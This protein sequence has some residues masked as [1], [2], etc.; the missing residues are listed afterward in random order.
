VEGPNNNS[1]HQ[2]FKRVKKGGR[3]SASQ[4]NKLLDTV[5]RL[6]GQS[7]Q[8]SKSYSRIRLV[9]MNEVMGHFDHEDYT[10][11]EDREGQ[12]QWYDTSAHTID[13]TGRDTQIKA[14]VTDPWGLVYDDNERLAVYYNEQSGKCIPLN[15]RTVRHAVTW[16]EI[17]GGSG[18]SQDCNV[19]F[20]DY[21]QAD[22]YP[23]VYPIKFIKIEYIEQA[24]QQ[25]ATTSYLN[26]TSCPDAYV[27]NVAAT[28]GGVADV[29]LPI[30]CPLQVYS[31]VGR[32]GQPQWFT[33]TCCE[34]DESSS[35]QSGSGSSSSQSQS[36]DS[37]SSGGSS[38]SSSESSQSASSSSSGGSSLSSNSSSGGS[39][40]SSGGSSGSSSGGS[41]MS[42]GGS[43]LSE[44]DLS[45]SGS[46]GFTCADFVT[47]LSFNSDTCVLTYCVKTVCFPDGLG[48][49]VSEESC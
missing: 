5:E 15:P 20:L 42:S 46:S 34:F 10:A 44:S 4:Q 22:E 49:T 47:R 11:Y 12:L 23:N 18:E 39:S 2:F 3:P 25:I 27:M 9:R 1:Q 13:D 40:D 36:S 33:H 35:S 16:Y 28:A 21:P 14:N 8:P 29:Y 7:N 45:V 41:S 38:L 32:N 48:I 24:G 37:T 19:G 43:S 6:S 31:V 26:P 17:N 30:F